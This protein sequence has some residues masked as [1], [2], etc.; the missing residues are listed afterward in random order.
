MAGDSPD[1]LV[2][3]PDGARAMLVLGH[4]AGS[5]M[6]SPFL[7]G[8]CEAIA[9]LGVAT[10]RFDFP[11]RRA[12]RRAPDRAPVLIAAYREARDRAEQ[13]AGGLPLLAG[14]RSMGGRIGSMAAAEGMPVAG[15]VFLAYPL[16][17]PGRPEKIRDA[18]LYELRCP[19]LFLQGTRDAFA[20]PPLLEAVLTRLGSRAELISI[21]GGDHSFH[22]AGGTRDGRRIGASLAPAAADFA[23]RIA[24]T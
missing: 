15:L 5:P 9:D 17:P 8:F 3:H 7:Q 11:Y 23:H 14:G 4:G 22:V 19:M 21:E 20:Q 12:G 1:D 2:I 18:H 13:L 16:H 24:A 10:Y 6:T